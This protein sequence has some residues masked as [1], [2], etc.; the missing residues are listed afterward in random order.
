[1]TSSE[2]PN[3][4]AR[5]TDGYYTGGTVPNFA[6]FNFGGRVVD[7]TEIWINGVRLG[8]RQVPTEPA[9]PVSGDDARE[10]ELLRLQKA[11]A[12]ANLQA[13]YQS[14]MLLEAGQEIRMLEFAVADARLR[15]RSTLS[16]DGKHLEIAKK[17][18]D[19]GYRALALKNHPD[20]GGD[21]RAMAAI[22]SAIEALR[23]ALERA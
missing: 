15:A 21:Q 16:L 1:M 9:K 4:W 17:I 6:T 19:A 11:L 5:D 12:R 7:Q 13:T 22:N 23:A 20:R 8:R 10:M 2:D 18:V 3:Q 14:R